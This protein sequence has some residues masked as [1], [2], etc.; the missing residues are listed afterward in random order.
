MTEILVK[1]FSPDGIAIITT[2]EHEG[3]Q[4]L[5]E[6]FGGYAYESEFERMMYLAATDVYVSKQLQQGKIN[7]A[8][9]SHAGQCYIQVNI[10]PALSD[11]LCSESGIALILSRQAV[12]EA[13]WGQHL[14]ADDMAELDA[15]LQE[16]EHS[17]NLAENELQSFILCYMSDEERLAMDAE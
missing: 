14:H 4:R 7:L 9:Q 10:S 2:F 15:A 6:D 5:M 16:I 3:I 17:A 13:L 11:V 8:I 12:D 1:H